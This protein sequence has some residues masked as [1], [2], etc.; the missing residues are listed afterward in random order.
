MVVKA[1]WHFCK[2]RRLS[3]FAAAFTRS[4]LFCHLLHDAH[5]VYES[6]TE[7]A[8]CVQVEKGGS[9]D[10]AASACADACATVSSTFLL[11]IYAYGGKKRTRA[12]YLQQ[13]A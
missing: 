2:I 10:V 12:K 4:A 3:L 7:V 1:V 9:A 13:G 11:Y 6:Q 8:A 5:A